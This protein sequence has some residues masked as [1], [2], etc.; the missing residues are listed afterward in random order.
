VLFLEQD[1]DY[2]VGHREDRWWAAYTGGG[3]VYLPLVMVDS[4]HRISNGD[5]N[6]FEAVYRAMV[7]AELVRPPRAEIEAYSRRVGSRVRVYAR[8]VN[9][10]ATPLS[11]PR[12]DATV[13]ALVWEDVRVGVT[14]R[15]VRAAPWAG[16]STEV[17]DGAAFTATLETADLAN[18][19]WN[20]LH[21]V[22]LADYVPG[23]GPAYD[24]LQA[25]V[26]EPAGLYV[27][28]D[29]VTLA[30]D[31]GSPT[32]RSAALRVRGP[33]VLAWT[34]VTD[35]AWI[36][37]T[38]D[39]GTAGSEPSVTVRGTALS[40]GWQE[41]AATLT[42]SSQDGMS[43]ARTVTV[44]AYLGTRVL[45]IATVP[46]TRGATVALPVTL[47]ALGD[48]R[49][50]A[51][52]AAF[53]PGALGDAS[54]T[55]GAD[56]DGA[57]VT[58]DASAP[59]PGRVGVTVALPAGRTFQQGSREL[60][61]ISLAVSPSPTGPARVAIADD[62]VPRQLRDSSGTALSASYVDGGVTLHGES[63]TR[64]PRRHLARGPR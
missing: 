6:D 39:H 48:E 13:H 52:S 2:P 30:V 18:V 5:Q 61:V 43:F 12:N 40:P 9:G 28:P 4:G 46:G 22:V 60:V 25:A 54:V 19:N 23:P 42:A 53:D 58:V 35:S 7:N 32:D 38:P 37:V 51:F 31:A 10:A 36:T 55:A 26:A 47:D 57:V 41:G 17:A 33:Y 34:A 21:T 8:V 3:S 11:T 49:T 27:E 24:M 15:F 62:P 1:V 29:T 64:P 44:R 63:L 20:A 50:V 16:F 45:R 14:S 59:A 56:A